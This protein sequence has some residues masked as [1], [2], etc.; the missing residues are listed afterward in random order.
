[1]MLCPARKRRTSTIASMSGKSSALRK[2][3][4]QE[5][6]PRRLNAPCDQIIID[7]QRDLL[8]LKAHKK[9]FASSIR[10]KDVYGN[11]EN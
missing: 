7:Q 11:L 2:F 9:F 6:R 3:S 5:P 10:I 4:E 8:L 1:M